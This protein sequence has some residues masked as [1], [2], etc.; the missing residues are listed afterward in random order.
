MTLENEPPLREHPAKSDP[1]QLRALKTGI[2][3]VHTAVLIGVGGVL[4]NLANTTGLQNAALG[5][6]SLVILSISVIANLAGR[7]LAWFAATG[8]VKNWLAVSIGLELLAYCVGGISL[9]SV[10]P[11][12]VSIAA[13]VAG[14]I[15]LLAFLVALRRLAQS[16]GLDHLAQAA[17]KT[18]TFL[19]YSSGLALLGLIVSLAD[20]Q[21]PGVQ[22]EFI[23]TVIWLILAAS[24]LMGLIAYLKFL[25][26]MERFARD[27]C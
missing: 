8:T 10:G 21:V 27:Y 25:H 1:T 26:L 24:A 23:K 14:I 9:V 22:Q 16:A 11:V 7:T 20:F 17:D 5:Y 13:G 15:S 6:S 3:V 12:W 19:A 4:L 2:R 18:F